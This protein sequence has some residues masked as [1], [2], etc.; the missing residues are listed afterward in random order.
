[1]TKKELVARLRKKFNAWCSNLPDVE[2]R[3]C[4]DH[5]EQIRPDGWTKGL[6]VLELAAECADEHENWLNM[7]CKEERKQMPEESETQSQRPNP[8]GLGLRVK[9]TASQ[10]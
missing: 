10:R 1:M 4:N 9:E 6:E 2:Y 5:A 8:E 3:S 7:D